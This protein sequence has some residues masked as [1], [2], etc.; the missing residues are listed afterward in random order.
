[1]KNIQ[2]RCRS[3]NNIS[4]FNP[5]NRIAFIMFFFYIE[6]GKLIAIVDTEIRTVIVITIDRA[7]Y[8]VNN[9]LSKMCIF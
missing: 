8:K 4:S 7:F 9:N 1:M 3:S 6:R 5:T 2:M